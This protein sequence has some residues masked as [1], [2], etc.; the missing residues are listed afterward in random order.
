M[1]TSF[2]H[3]NSLSFTYDGAPEALF[4]TLSVTVPRGWSGVVG[5]NGCGKSTLL[6]LIAGFLTPSEGSVYR[7]GAVYYLEQRDDHPPVGL[8]EFLWEGGE[9]GR[10][11]GMLRVGDDWPWRWESLSHGERKRAQVAYALSRAPEVLLVD[12]PTNHVDRPTREVIVAALERYEGVGLVVSHDRELLDRLCARCLF[13]RSPS[14]V[15]VR[16]GGVSE[17]LAQEN[18]ER[19]RAVREREQAVRH[20]QRIAREVRQRRTEADRQG[21]KR[22]KR[23]LD[24]KDSDGRARIGLAILTGQDGQAGRRARR[25]EARYEQAHREREEREEEVARVYD[26]RSGKM[27]LRWRGSTS[28]GDRVLWWKAHRV[29]LAEGRVL[30]VDDMALARSMRVGVEGVNGAGKTTLLRHARLPDGRVLGEVA[31]SP[32]WMHGCGVVLIEQELTP[33]RIGWLSERLH[34]LSRERRGEVLA[35]VARLGSDPRKVDESGSLSPGEARKLQLALAIDD[36]IHALVLDEPTNH[37]DLDTVRTLEQM[38]SGFAGALLVV[39]HDAL[40]LDAVCRSRWSLREEA[41]EVRI[42][43]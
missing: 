31:S 20:E 12:E 39:S 19:E 17:G 14:H 28:G 41:G 36:S 21:A 43:R 13:V 10:L 9:S 16:P 4:R 40:F 18:G 6:R 11:K 7:P 8:D 26:G 29:P 34:D 33:S 15:T 23:G 25:M 1:D 5:A 24:T 27:G 30:V 22:S 42:A 2:L 38:L 37:L 35:R 32:E 3:I